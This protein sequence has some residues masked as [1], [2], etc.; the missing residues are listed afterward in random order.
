[1]PWLDG[2]RLD[3]TRPGLV[4]GSSTTRSPTAGGAGLA[5]SGASCACVGGV[6]SSRQRLMTTDSDR[7]GTPLSTGAVRRGRLPGAETCVPE[8]SVPVNPARR[9]FGLAAPRLRGN[10]IIGGTCEHKLLAS[11]GF[12]SVGMAIS[13]T[14]RLVSCSRLSIGTLWSASSIGQMPH[15]VHENHTAT[16][17]SDGEVQIVGGGSSGTSIPTTLVE[18][19]NPGRNEWRT[20]APLPAPRSLHSA[21]LLA[22]GDVLVTGGSSR[23]T[24]SC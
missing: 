9:V 10:G 17:L 4:S 12:S 18:R 24:C 1:M 16:L 7:T 19:Y 8:C 3:W 21:T 14:W 13:S 2:Q 20:V 11:R 22:D 5:P 23:P 6:K 15:S